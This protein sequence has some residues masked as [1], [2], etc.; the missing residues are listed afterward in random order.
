MKKLLHDLQER[1]EIG[2]QYDTISGGTAN[3]LLELVTKLQALN[4]DIVRKG[5]AGAVCDEPMV[6]CDRCGYFSLES[7]TECEHCSQTDS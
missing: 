1:I 5:E 4:L 7:N 3:D 6:K 2:L